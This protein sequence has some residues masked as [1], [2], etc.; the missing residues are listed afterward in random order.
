MGV[1]IA[2]TTASTTTDPDTCCPTV[3]STS[4]D[5]VEAVEL[6]GGFSALSDPIRLRI[7]NM[8]ASA[9]T[10]EICVCEFVVPLGRSQ[11]TIS[12]H[13]KLLSD[14]GL[15]SSER[16]G[17]WSWYSINR[18]RLEQLRAALAG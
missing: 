6:S 7:L 12:H 10:G 2:T 3:L 1:I 18:D 4:L 11:P 15:V 13:L 17:K 5:A 9:P 8:L 14:A 16:R